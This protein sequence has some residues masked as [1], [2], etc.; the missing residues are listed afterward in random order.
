[1]S[2]Q[3]PQALNQLSKVFLTDWGIDLLERFIAVK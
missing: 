3:C 2:A 1:M